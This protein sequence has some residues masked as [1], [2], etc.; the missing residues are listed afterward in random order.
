MIKSFFTE[1][2]RAW[3]QD[4]QGAKV[5]LR[6]IGCGALILQ[7]SYERGTKDS[8]VFETA[9]LTGMTK[10]RL[11]EIAGPGSELHRRSRLYIDIVG[12]GIPFLPHGPIWHPMS[13]LNATLDRLELVVLDV[14]DVVVSKLKRFS[15]NDQSDIDAMIDLGL[16]PHDRL[17]DRFCAAVDEFSG[18]ARAS[19]LPRYVANL[20]RVERDMLSASETEIELP[21]W[22]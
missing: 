22:I 1:I 14:V 12:N 17:I 8:D 6:I 15:S 3:P 4:A 16:V 2:D 11:L 5:R 18:D 9:E 21:S 20:H 10:Q 7:A 19:D 13:E